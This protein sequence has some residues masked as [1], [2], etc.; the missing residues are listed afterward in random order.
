M[1]PE[2]W[3]NP[4]AFIPERFLR[5]DGKQTKVVKPENFMPFGVGQRM[6]LGD[7]LAEKEFF[8]FFSSIM[9]LFNFELPEDADLPSL[10]GVAGV[11]VTPEEFKVKFIPRLP[12]LRENDDVIDVN[13]N[14]MMALATANL[15]KRTLV[16]LSDQ[17]AP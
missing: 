3:E 9:H 4:E 15:C 1:S 8:L 13:N 14:E 12:G 11:T 10:E 17:G 7:Q 6:C 5:N 2:Y 16:Q